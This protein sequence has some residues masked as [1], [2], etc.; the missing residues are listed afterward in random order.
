MNNGNRV[1]GT[2]EFANTTGSYSFVSGGT[3]GLLRA[4]V[5]LNTASTSTGNVIGADFRN[6]R[7]SDGTGTVTFSG[8]GSASLTLSGI[9]GNQSA[10]RPTAIDKTS[11]GVL[12]FSGSAANTYT[13]G[14]AVSAGRLELSKTAGLDAISGSTLTISGGEVRHINANQINNTTAVT[15]SGGH[16]NLNNNAETLGSLSIS[17]SSTL[18]LGTGT[19]TL[20]GASTTFASGQTLNLGISSLASFGRIDA[21]SNLLS[22]A[23]TLNVTS[24]HSFSFGDSFNLFDGQLE[25]AFSSIS[26]P[27]LSAGLQWDTNSLYS[28]GVISV[29][30]EPSAFAALAGLAAVGFAATRRRRR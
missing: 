25:G 27:S 9:V 8:T 3:S 18:S 24:T 5:I 29:I 17:G 26:L 1:T 6:A 15:I 23:G 20:T 28:S 4:N 22:F 30:P 19:L 14:T 7:G 21:G 10:A 11:T 13:A 16:L 12:I 2:L